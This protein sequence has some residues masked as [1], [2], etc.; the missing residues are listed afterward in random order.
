MSEQ[1]WTPVGRAHS[2]G[3]YVP[4]VGD[5]LRLTLEV[6]VGE[7]ISDFG[8]HVEN[9]MGSPSHRI[10]LNQPDVQS[11]EVLVPKPDEPQGLG[12]VVEDAEKRRWVRASIPAGAVFQWTEALSGAVRYYA[13]IE[14]V[15]VLSE[16]V[17]P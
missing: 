9:H 7:A 17:Q 14:V 6:K 3:G 5:R 16:G 4:K 2:S 13:D 10:Y 12:A 11:I 1:Q 8:I 15:R